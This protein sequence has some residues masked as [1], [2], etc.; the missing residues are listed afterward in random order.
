M[1]PPLTG[2]TNGCGEQPCVVKRAEDVVAAFVVTRLETGKKRPRLVDPRAG[3]LRSVCSECPVIVNG[4][5]QAPGLPQ[6]CQS[7]DAAQAAP[8]VISNTCKERSPPANNA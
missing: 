1:M 4:G 6:S 7:L 5:F 2:G 3:A 8:S